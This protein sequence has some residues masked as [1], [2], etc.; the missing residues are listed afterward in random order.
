MTVEAA[1]RGRLGAF[2]LDVAFEAPGAGVTALAGP[3]GSGK[4]SLLRCLAGL[5][6]LP[7]RLRCGGVTWQDESRFVPPHKRQI[8]FVFQDGN[9][10]PHL[11]VRQNLA[12]AAKRAP[13]GR[14]EA[15]DV[16]ARTGIAGLLDRSAGRLSGGEA[17][18]V[19]IARALLRQPAMLLLDE[20]LAALDGAAKAGLHFYLAQ[21]LP[22]LGIPVFY[23]SHDPSEVAP[24]AGATITLDSGRIAQPVT[25]IIRSS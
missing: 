13:P 23:V 19:A 20:P 18:R 3:S 21:V 17:R 22:G 24:I 25:A 2:A 4:T 8:G 15:K 9:A 11:S 16:I 5:E 1:F 6:H 14:F 7:G 12:Y 10:L